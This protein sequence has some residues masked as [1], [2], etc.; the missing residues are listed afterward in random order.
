MVVFF[1][2]QKCSI[3]L[4]FLII[5][6]NA[7]FM[8]QI[9]FFFVWCI[10][11]LISLKKTYRI[12]YN[13]LLQISLKINPTF[14]YVVINKFFV[15]IWTSEVLFTMIYSTIKYINIKNLLKNSLYCSLYTV[16]CS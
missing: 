5:V 12:N 9:Y 7:K 4:P 2:F 15:S 8:S 1:Y 14:Q 16:Y 3:F 11:S 6:L 13:I 10:L